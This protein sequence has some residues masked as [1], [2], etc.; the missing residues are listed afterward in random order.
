[1]YGMLLP[2]SLFKH[3]Y[4]IAVT[5][6]AL[7]LTPFMNSFSICPNSCILGERVHSVER[8]VFASELRGLAEFDSKASYVLLVLTD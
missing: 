3:C 4:R 2:I 1:M 8:Y 7:T 5:K 6:A